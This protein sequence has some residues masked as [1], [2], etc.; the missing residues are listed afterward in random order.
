VA[1][2]CLF[3]AM[4]LTFVSALRG[5]GDMRFILL[6]TIVVAPVPVLVAWLGMNPYWLEP[7]LGVELHGLGLIWCWWVITGW[8]CVIGM[9]YCFRFLQG[10][11]KQMRVIE[12]EAIVEGELES[13][14]ESLLEE[15]L[16]R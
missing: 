2:Y 5:A 1:A 11:W 6:T 13:K 3:D 14:A 12:S 10:R 7:I 9:I 4:N 16:V 8:I 15:E